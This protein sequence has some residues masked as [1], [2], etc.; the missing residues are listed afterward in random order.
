MQ[1]LKEFRE[2]LLRRISGLYDRLLENK[3]FQALVAEAKK[4]I[5]QVSTCIC[6]KPYYYCLFLDLLVFDR[7][8]FAYCFRLNGHCLLFLSGTDGSLFN[9]FFYF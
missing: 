5:E 3:Q 2:R 7:T 1:E 6:M 4:Y 8:S 9:E